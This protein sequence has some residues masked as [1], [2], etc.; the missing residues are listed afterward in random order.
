MI[1]L[2]PQTRQFLAKQADSV[3]GYAYAL[4]FTNVAVGGNA[5][6]VITTQAGWDFQWIKGTC[7]AYNHAALTGITNSTQ[8][9]PIASIQIQDQTRGISLFSAPVP[10]SALFGIVANGSLPMEL[11]EPY[12]IP[13]NTTLSCT[14]YNG[15]S[16]LAYDVHLTMFGI[17]CK[18]Y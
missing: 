12:F 5:T 2:A 1:A 4:D 14:L 3:R 17:N 16:A 18:N 11:P 9:V 13:A 8:I 15:D 7:A 10:V 6:V